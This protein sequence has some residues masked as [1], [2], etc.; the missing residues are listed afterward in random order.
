M[1]SSPT[2]PVVAAVWKS[3]LWADVCVRLFLSTL[4]LLVLRIDHGEILEAGAD[5]RVV[6]E[7]PRGGLIDE[8]PAADLRRVARA[9]RGGRPVGGED[10]DGQC[11]R[12]AAPASATRDSALRVAPVRRSQSTPMTKRPP[13]TPMTDRAS[14]RAP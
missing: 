5:D 4:R 11:T 12:S 3:Q 9:Q 7:D 14:R 13:T 6:G 2:R 8:H 10:D 1:R